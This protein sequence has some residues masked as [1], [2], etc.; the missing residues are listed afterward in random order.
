M[1]RLLVVGCMILALSGCSTLTAYPPRAMDTALELSA[2]SAFLLPDV[3]VTCKDVGCRN[4]FINAHVRATDLNYGDWKKS[5]WSESS[6]MNLGTSLVTML[7]G[8]LGGLGVGGHPLSHT[9]R[10]GPQG[11]S[12]ARL[13]SARQR[14]VTRPSSP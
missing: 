8:G 14:S 13:R 11:S 4:Q 12:G 3:A 2:L 5:I 7:L 6:T 1:G 9:W 10:L